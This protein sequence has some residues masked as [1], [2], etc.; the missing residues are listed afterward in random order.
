MAKDGVTELSGNDFNDFVK[1][2]LVLI[3]FWAEWCMP[4][5][6]MA[7]VTE[8]LDKKMK[9]KVKFG[10]VNVDENQ[11]LAAKHQV[12]SIPNFVLFENG[13]PKD[14]FVG[15]MPVEEFEEKLKEHL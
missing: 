12:R 6:M 3:D 2:G 9:G 11:Q 4:C 5:I 7:P 15:A 10:K 14:R 1:D 8:E 13:K